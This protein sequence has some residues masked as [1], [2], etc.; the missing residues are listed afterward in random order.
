MTY[1]D[2]SLNN[3]KMGTVS[4]IFLS[5]QVHDQWGWP[6][7]SPAL[8]LLLLLSSRA[9]GGR[10]GT[11]CLGLVLGKRVHLTVQRS[12]IINTADLSQ[13]GGLP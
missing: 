5:W 3:C 11:A 2:L 1:L 6:F 13:V 10:V 7:L 8:L 4:E 12:I 9:S